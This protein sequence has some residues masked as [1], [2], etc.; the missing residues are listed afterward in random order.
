MPVTR[1]PAPVWMSAQ[2]FRDSLRNLRSIFVF[3]PVLENSRE[4]SLGRLFRTASSAAPKSTAE[5]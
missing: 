1:N 5:R 4:P 3:R 2:T